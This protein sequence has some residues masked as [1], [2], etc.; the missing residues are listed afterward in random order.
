M[1]PASRT[2]RRVPS[3]AAGARTAS[4]ANAATTTARDFVG[5]RPGPGEVRRTV[6][7][8]RTLRAAAARTLRAAAARTLRAGDVPGAAPT[9]RSARR[10]F[11][12]RRVG[13][14]AVRRIY[15]RAAQMRK[16]W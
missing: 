14:E 9:G 15:A 12:P 11:S 16:Y 8:A 1:A 13:S 2:A 7:A 5:R 6:A 3:G 10:I 4:T